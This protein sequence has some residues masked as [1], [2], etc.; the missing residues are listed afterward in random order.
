MKLTS[1]LGIVF[2]SSIYIVPCYKV[3]KVAEEFN[4]S[5]HKIEN[6]KMTCSRSVFNYN[7]VCSL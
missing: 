1:Q 5:D 4:T 7:K 6:G 2:R 3:Q